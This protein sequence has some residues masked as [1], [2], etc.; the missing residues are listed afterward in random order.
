MVQEDRLAKANVYLQKAQ[1]ELDVKQAE[2]DA[3]QADYDKV[4]IKKQ[5]SG[6]TSP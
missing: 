6:F 1:A 4:L 5:V 2:L 3:V